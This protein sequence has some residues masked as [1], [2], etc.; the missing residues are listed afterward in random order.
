MTP[1]PQP[2]VCTAAP[3]KPNWWPAK[4]QA[5]T[6]DYSL[7]ISTILAQGVDFISAVTAACAPSGSGELTISNP[8]ITNAVL[9]L[10]TAG[11]VPSR[12]YTV[13]WIVT[14]QDGRIYSFIVYQG[15]PPIPGYVVPVAPSPFFGASVSP[16][17]GTLINNGGVVNT[18]Y[19]GFATNTFGLP[20]GTFW[21]NGGEIDATPG[22][23]PVLNP[24][25]IPFSALTTVGL[26]SLNAS[27]F[28]IT[29][30]PAGSGFCWLNGDV[31]CVA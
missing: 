29:S 15:I 14:C 17:L 25:P 18:T 21:S 1:T 6:L 27:L 10:T 13:Q 8:V 4:L 20:P 28:P 16:D 26:Q 22:A 12:V 9:T 23:V 11:G 7:N 5:A 30:W 24:A 31:L 2:Y 3:P 19:T